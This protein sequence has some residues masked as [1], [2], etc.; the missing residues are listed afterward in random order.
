MV[1]IQCQI[2]GDRAISVVQSLGLKGLY[3]YT[4]AT[5][6]RDVPF[7]LIFFPSVALFREVLDP[8]MQNK[9]A[10]TFSSGILAGAIAAF[11]VTP[12]DVVKTRLQAAKSPGDPSYT[13]IVDCYTKLL[14]SGGP[15]QLFRGATA[16][17]LIVS[18]FSTNIAA[19]RYIDLNL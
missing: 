8:I 7:S 10:V 9:L 19:I 15:R 18:V 12:M 1:K 5:L 4:T 16:R 13:G 17:V 3:R 14:K 11:A 6:M 2:S